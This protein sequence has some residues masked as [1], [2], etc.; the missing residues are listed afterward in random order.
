MPRIDRRSTRVHEGLK[1]Y[2]RIVADLERKETGQ[3]SSEVPVSPQLSRKSW[4]QISGR[5]PD[6]QISQEGLLGN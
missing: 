3:A 6:A 2:R 1:P 4:C 5:K